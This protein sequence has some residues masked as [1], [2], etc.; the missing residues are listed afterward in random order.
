MYRECGGDALK[1]SGDFAAKPLTCAKTIL[2]AT[3]A[4]RRIK[5]KPQHIILKA[6]MG[7]P[8]TAG[9]VFYF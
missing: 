4:R 3:Q 8:M 1:P 6:F 2:P 5:T 9:T 7:I